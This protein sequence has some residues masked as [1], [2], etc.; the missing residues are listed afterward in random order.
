MVRVRS[1]SVGAGGGSFELAAGVTAM[2]GAT[3]LAAALFP[4]DQTQ[5]GLI[6]VAAAAGVCAAA[7]SRWRTAVAVTGV[8]YLL[9]TVFITG[10]GQLS[11]AGLTGQGYGLVFVVA[12]MIGLGY[13]HMRVVQA[14]AA[15]DAELRQLLR[16]AGPAG[17]DGQGLGR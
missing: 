1:W 17:D 14:E 5:T 8:G 9:C 10:Y 12:T 6:M 13:R 3:A 16:D 11:W 7:L 2:V 4:P 15:F